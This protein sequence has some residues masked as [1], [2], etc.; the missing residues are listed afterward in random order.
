MDNELLSFDDLADWG[1]TNNMSE[2]ELLVD[3]GWTKEQV[4]ESQ[5]KIQNMIHNKIEELELLKK[6]K[7][8][9][10]NNGNIK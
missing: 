5:C 2:E 7:E 3:L 4:E 9:V 6:C 8:L 1:E 10:S